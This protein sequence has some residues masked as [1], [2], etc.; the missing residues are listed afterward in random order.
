MHQRPHRRR[1]EDTAIGGTGNPYYLGIDLGTTFTAAAVCRGDS[2]SE[3]VDLGSHGPVAP[4]VVLLKDDG[5][6]L[7]GEAA[8]R[9]APTE[10]QRVAREFKRRVGDP[11]PIIVDGAPFAADA[12]MAKLLAWVANTVS[13][14]QGGQ[15]AGVAVTHPANWG[16]YKL[17]VLRQAIRAADL[18]NVSLVSEPEAAAIHY[19]TQERIAP[20]AIVAVYD[21]GG[22]TF[23]TAVLRHAPVSSALADP[24]AQSG[25]RWQ[26]LGHPEGI[27]RL[28]GVDVDEAVFRHVVEVTGIARELDEALESPTLA[29][30]DSTALHA[31]VHRLRQDCTTAKEALSSDT[32]AV[33]P[34]MLTVARQ[35]QVRLTRAELETMVRPTLAATISALERSLRSADVRAE[36][37]HSVLLVGGS[38][39][40]PLIGQLITSELGRPIA[41]DAHP[42]HSVALGAARVAAVTTTKRS[43]RYAAPSVSR[44]P[45]ALSYVAPV[46]ATGSAGTDTAEA[47]HL[48]GP[49]HSTATMDERTE[50]DAEGANLWQPSDD[51]SV[52][53]DTGGLSLRTRRRTSAQPSFAIPSGALG[54]DA[55]KIAVDEAASTE[56]DESDPSPEEPDLEGTRT[57]QRRSALIAITALLLLA[58]TGAFL[59][60]PSPSDDDSDGGPRSSVAV[61]AA[62]PDGT[63]DH[64]DTPNSAPDGGS[65]D[66]VEPGDDEGGAAGGS[67]TGGVGSSG[68]ADYGGA[69]GSGGSGGSN[70][71]GGS[72]G[73][74]PA[75][76]A[77]APTSESPQSTTTTT[78][79]PR[80]PTVVGMDLPTAKAELEAA[81]FVAAYEDVCPASDACQVTAQDPA[82]GRRADPGS[83]VHL[84]LEAV[85]A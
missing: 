51:D 48:R 23:D 55:E 50:S 28:G 46:G 43:A 20:G 12:L 2:S 40:I 15:P 16:A 56:P 83:S 70:S 38:S 32:D 10:P 63:G 64:A 80:V 77:P 5:E 49:S 61:P 62:S 26:V 35:S 34:V 8:Q 1:K 58:I 67:A 85:P 45:A 59:L 57:R 39:R 37:I 60:R 9:R 65:G 44:A 21:L 81:G 22:G 72:S 41:I 27:E 29:A 19:A 52:G 17:D 53:P 31:A 7:C 13:D 33:I 14:A 24:A 69:T 30:A 6:L 54:K 11:T 78:L 71:S 3:M 4:S 25:S 82:G 75:P 36:D 68:A 66:S 42:K 73:H 47:R 79:R 74:K 18:V 84:T 76:D